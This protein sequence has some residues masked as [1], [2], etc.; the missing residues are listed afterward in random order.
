M[1]MR[2][3]EYAPDPRLAAFVRCY[4]VFE[5]E[6]GAAAGAVAS[7]A[8]ADETIVPDGNPELVFHYGES[9]SEIAADAFGELRA[10]RQP[11]SL[12]AGQLTRPLTLRAN[13][14]RGVISVR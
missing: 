10:I 9:F 1:T 2:Y 14:A 3:A 12:F 6:T 4:W 7:V 13:G 5:A 11:Q 8:V